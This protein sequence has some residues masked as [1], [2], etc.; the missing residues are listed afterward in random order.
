MNSMGDT[1]GTREV[2][3]PIAQEQVKRW[4]GVLFKVTGHHKVDD[5]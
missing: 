2:P 3:D 4:I 5:Q 1:D